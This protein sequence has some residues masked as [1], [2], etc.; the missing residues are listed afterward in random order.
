MAVLICME[1]PGGH[2]PVSQSRVYQDTKN[3]IK[4]CMDPNA[5]LSHGFPDYHVDFLSS[6]LSC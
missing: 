4:R 5:S 6:K 2:H 3:T 1:V